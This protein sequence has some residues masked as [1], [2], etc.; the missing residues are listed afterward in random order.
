MIDG[1]IGGYYGIIKN[2]AEPLGLTSV[3][4]YVY[5]GGYYVLKLI[6]GSG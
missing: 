3:M 6:E 5:V 1:V 2:E 4:I